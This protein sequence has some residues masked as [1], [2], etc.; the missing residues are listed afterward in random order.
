MNYRCLDDCPGCASCTGVSAMM[1]LRPARRL[2]LKTIL[3]VVTMLSLMETDPVSMSTTQRPT[4]MN[5]LL[6]H[7]S[8]HS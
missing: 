3:L 1:H 6:L 2:K 7:H 5:L 8:G 4:M